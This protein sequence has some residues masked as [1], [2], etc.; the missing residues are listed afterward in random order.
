MT[1]EVWRQEKRQEI[2][3]AI[4][5]IAHKMRETTDADQL[6][7]LKHALDAQKALLNVIGNYEKHQLNIDKLEKSSV[8]T[9]YHHPRNSRKV[10]KW[11]SPR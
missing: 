1:H 7:S 11:R 4:E 2:F 8:G 3:D 6:N 10:G 9:R 5:S